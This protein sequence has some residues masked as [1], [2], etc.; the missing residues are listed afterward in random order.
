M[1]CPFSRGCGGFATALFIGEIRLSRDLILINDLL[2][3][4]SVLNRY[5]IIEVLMCLVIEFLVC[6]IIEGLVSLVIKVLVSHRGFWISGQE[7]LPV[8]RLE[9]ALVEK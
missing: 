6:R 7:Y 1:R 5:L 9:Q 2:F 8:S 3:I 4:A